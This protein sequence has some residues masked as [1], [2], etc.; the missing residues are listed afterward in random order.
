MCNDEYGRLDADLHRRFPSY[1]LQW[2]QRDDLIR[3]ILD[4][5]RRLIALENKTQDTA[6]EAK[7]E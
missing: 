7:K 2:D 6:T 3:A 1:F 5:N 4:L